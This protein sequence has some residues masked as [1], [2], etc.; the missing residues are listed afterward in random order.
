MSIPTIGDGPRSPGTYAAATDG[1]TGSSEPRDQRSSGFRGFAARHPISALLIMV[2]S[3]AYPVM[4]TVAL[5]VHGVIPG[6]RLLDRLP[7]PP[8]EVAGLLLTMLALLPAAIYVTWAADGKEGLATLL[9]RVT[10]WRFG[11]GWWLFILIAMPSLTMVGGLLLGDSYRPVDPMA[12][13]WSQLWQLV[14][15]L[16]LVNL[17]EET[18]WAGVVQTRL[19]RRH[20]VFIAALITAVPFGFVHLPLGFMGDFTITSVAI[21]LIGPVLLG[22]LLR[23]MAA[24]TMRGA[25]D[26]V[27][28][29]AL[30]HSMFN[31]SNND[32]GI[33]ATLLD[34]D[35]YKVGILAVLVVLTIPLALMMRRRLG[36]SYRRRLEAD[37]TQRP[38]AVDAEETGVQRD[39]EANGDGTGYY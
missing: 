16:V 33:V 13:L 18:A 6:K 21:S 22:V 9:R 2:F 24:L 26:S 35:A 8:D 7:I 31:R 17:W 1:A 23:P 30:V 29:F 36:P 39:S 12:F 15:Q 25:R 38:D 34:G 27:L 19:E 10:R 37:P 5:A 20:N 28:A 4:F 3:I 11:I 32:N 14:I